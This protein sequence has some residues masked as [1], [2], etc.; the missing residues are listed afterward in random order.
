MIEWK[1]SELSPV[2]ND[3]RALSHA[4]LVF[5][6]SVMMYQLVYLD[7]VSF[8]ENKNK[9]FL[10][11]DF[12]DNLFVFFSITKSTKAYPSSPLPLWLTFA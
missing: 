12:F 2:S 6:L 5:E 1:S 11:I 7:A 8:R 10:D 9:V 3:V 4:L